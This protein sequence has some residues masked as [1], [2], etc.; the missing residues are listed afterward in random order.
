MRVV[1][2]V[3]AS[4]DI[5]TGH[6]MRCL[7]LAARLRGNGSE[8]FF[9]CREVQGHL[10]DAIEAAGFS[11][12]RLPVAPAGLGPATLVAEGVADVAAFRA[13]DARQTRMAIEECGMNPDLLVVDHYMLDEAWES[14]LR[15]TV[16]RIFVID[17]LANRVHDC[18]LLLDQNLHDSP[19]SR[20]VGLVPAGARVFV[21]PK[22]ALLRPEFRV[23]CAVP[24][25]AGLRRMMVFFGG[26]DPTDE[27]SKVIQ[28]LHSLGSAAPQTE[29]VLGSSNPNRERVFSAAAGLACVRVHG[30]TNDMAGLMREAD[31]GVGTCGVAAWERCC[32][33]LPSLVVV[34]ADNQRDDAR[35][36]D[37]MGAARNLGDAMSARAER[38]ASEI[39][40]LQG[41]PE[42]LAAMSIAAGSIMQG[43]IEAACELEAALGS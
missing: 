30:Q 29:L 28:A 36:L 1:I 3:D 15:R 23:A 2:R 11:C 43:Q 7:T 9:I 8:I 21:G 38:W 19:D 20:Y 39:R 26:V 32:L 33:G 31:L 22:Y 18:D 41:E 5:G 12:S 14:A 25:N 16:G 37:A 35:I 40:D 42:S 6:V 34:N 4:V 17:D 10:C 24:R 27:A 13:M